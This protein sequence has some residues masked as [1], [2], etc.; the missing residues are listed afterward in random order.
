MRA[1]DRGRWVAVR[2]LD[3]AIRRL[4]LPVKSV[5]KR[6]RAEAL[7]LGD[8]ARVRRYRRQSQDSLPVPP[9]RLRCRVG[10]NSDIEGFIAVGRDAGHG[11]ERGLAAGGRTLDEVERVLDF[12]CGCGR[13]VRHLA[14]RRPEVRWDGCDVDGEA[15]AWLRENFEAVQFQTT[16]FLPPLDY[17]D[18]AFDLVYSVSVFTHLDEALQRKWLRELSRVLRP[19]G[20]M[21]LSVHGEY[22]Y[23]TYRSQRM[24]VSQ[25]LAKRM[26]R[27]DS[28]ARERFVFEPYE[29]STWN[30]R[31]FPGLDGAYGLAFHDV[32][33]VHQRWSELL[34]VI[35][36]LPTAINDWQDLVIARQRA[37]VAPDRSPA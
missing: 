17:P 18:D 6:L 12:G 8:P 31:D 5:L 2:R 33:Y 23:E 15:I 28:L 36:I 20:L 21:L 27:H 22:A 32:D 14:S 11:I 34:E 19:D 35:A 25:S 29:R 16:R 4:P 13:I 26:S 37:R 1:S 7:E 30:E 3:R 24:V 10:G 9:V